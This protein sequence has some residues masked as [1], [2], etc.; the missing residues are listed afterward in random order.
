MVNY[1]RFEKAR[2]KRSLIGTA[3]IKNDQKPQ[4][5][6]D[7][8]SW[9]EKWDEMKFPKSEKF[10]LSERKSSAMKQTLRY[11]TAL[12]DD[13]LTDGFDFVLTAGIQCDSLERR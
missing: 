1:F 11:Q 4:L 2:N 13:V 3:G 6:S 8:A 7:L 10:S 9:I 5:L 12:I